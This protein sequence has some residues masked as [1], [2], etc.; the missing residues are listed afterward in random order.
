MYKYSR[1]EELSHYHRSSSTSIRSS[2]L[3][4][5][6][7]VKY[8]NLFVCNRNRGY[9]TISS[10]RNISGPDRSHPRMRHSYMNSR[11]RPY[12]IPYERQR[13]P[14]PILSSINYGG[15]RGETIDLYSRNDFYHQRAPPISAVDHYRRGPSIRYVF[16]R[17]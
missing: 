4:D 15:M 12:D 14:P 7:Q 5:F 16:I 8:I 2:R 13:I 3:V 10:S 9:P 11:S 1:R 6:I 17:A